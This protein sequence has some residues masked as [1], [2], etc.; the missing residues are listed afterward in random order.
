VFPLV[1]DPQNPSTLYAVAHG[2]GVG[3]GTGVTVYARGGLFKSTDGGGSWNLAGSG[4]PESAEGVDVQVQNLAIDPQNPGT[5]YAGGYYG[6][7]KS[8]NGG[9]DWSPVNSGLPPF[10]TGP[11]ML[12]N[13]IVIDPRQPDTIYAAI[14]N[15]SIGKVFK[16]TNGGASWSDASSGLAEG[17]WV[18]SLQIDLQIPTTLYAG[19]KAGVYKSTDAGT[20]WAAINS[21]L[22]ATFISDVAIDPRDPR[23]LYAATSYGLVKTTDGGMNWSPETGLLGGAAPLAIDPQHASTV[24]AEGCTAVSICGVIKSTDGGTSWNASSILQDPYDEGIT[25]LAIDPRNSNIV[26]ATKRSDECFGETLRKSV[27]GGV[28]WSESRFKDIG[29]LATCVLALLVDPQNSANLYAAFQDGGVFKSTDA[30]A[31]WNAANSGLSPDSPFNTVVALAIDPSNPKTLYAVSFSGVFKSN[32]AGMSWNPSS[33]GLPDWS[34]KY[35]NPGDPLFFARLVVDPQ[36]STR[37]YLGI[38]I[39]GVERVFQSSDGSA[40]WIDSGLVVSV[41]SWFGGLAIS[42][43]GTVYA[44]SAEGVFRFYAPGT[45]R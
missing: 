17:A 23:T 27:D 18:S 13:S 5:L 9:A 22:T 10:E 41:A 36:D 12:V 26:Y 40:S 38:G 28:T 39:G 15:L 32:D 31:T 11:S 24:F 19:T 34:S 42:S 44:G 45:R 20:S 14:G 6:M 37:V 21:G 35:G 3:S 33:S 8:T 29:V 25:T 1:I 7:F 30:G 43:Q 2:C 4:L 16:T